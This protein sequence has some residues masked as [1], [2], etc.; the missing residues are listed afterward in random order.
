MRGKPLIA[1]DPRTRSI[2]HL[3]AE[4]TRKTF[5][6]RHKYGA[7]RTEVDGVKFASKAEAKRYSELRLLEKAGKIRNLKLQP[8]YELFAGPR[9]DAKEILIKKIAVYVADFEYESDQEIA[10]FWLKRVE[11]VKGRLGEAASLRLRVFKACYPEIA[12]HPH[13]KGQS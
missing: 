5:Q 13:R 2:S 4:A 1:G 11:D 7:V 6:R 3:G 8:R 10:G 12:V 9:P